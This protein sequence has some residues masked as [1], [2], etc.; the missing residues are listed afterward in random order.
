MFEPYLPRDTPPDWDS[1][2]RIRIGWIGVIVGYTEWRW[3]TPDEACRITRASKRALRYWS[4]AALITFMS[5]GPNYQRRY[6]RPE[7]E[8][9]RRIALGRPVTTKLLRQVIAHETR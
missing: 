6:M 7:L 1:A 5:D 2:D 4:D 9:V 3:V 8:A